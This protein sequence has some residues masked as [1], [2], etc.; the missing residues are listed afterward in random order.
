MPCDVHLRG[1][2]RACR[3]AAA[4]AILASVP[5]AAIKVAWLAGSSVG[6]TS[7]EAATEL[8]DRRHTFE[9]DSRIAHPLFESAWASSQN[10]RSRAWSFSHGARARR[11]IFGHVRWTEMRHVSFAV[12]VGSGCMRA[13][14]QRNRRVLLDAA[15]GAL[16]EVGRDAPLEL[17]ARRA[18]V[19]IATLYRHF[20]ERASLVAA[21]AVDVMSRTLARGARCNGRGAGRIRARCDGTCIERWMLVRLRSCRCLVRECAA[22]PRWGRYWTRRRH[23]RLS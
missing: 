4:V 12:E 3:A 13:D 16:L 21:V 10:P 23:C 1:A 15:I 5:Y 18:R 8:H 2:P 9:L 6:S 11:G 7:L 19:G 22:S 17:I 20:P 14:A